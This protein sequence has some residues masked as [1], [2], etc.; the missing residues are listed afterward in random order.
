MCRV[1]KLNNDGKPVV[2]KMNVTV[3]HS[4]SM[5]V[6][7]TGVLRSNRISVAASK[8]TGVKTYSSHRK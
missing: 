2:V 7:Q 8:A 3:K 6:L 4:S 1:Y 5:G